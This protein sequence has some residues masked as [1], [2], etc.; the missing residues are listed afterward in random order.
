MNSSEQR[1][2]SL[3]KNLR[4]ISRSF[5]ET[6]DSKPNWLDFGKLRVAYAEAGSDTDVPAYSNKLFYGV[7]ASQFGGQPVGNFGAVVPNANLKPMRIAETE[8]GMEFKMLRGRLG[9]DFAVYRKITSDQIVN[10]QIS[11]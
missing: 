5:S 11:D 2:T 10:A 6:F 1:F 4:N 7:N 9:L 8:V 3:V